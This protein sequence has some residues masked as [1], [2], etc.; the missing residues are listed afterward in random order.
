MDLGLWNVPN[1]NATN[2]QGSASPERSGFS[3]AFFVNYADSYTGVEWSMV[4]ISR[5]RGRS[6][7][8]S[9]GGTT[10]YSEIGRS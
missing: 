10:R 2:R 9:E 7:I 3:W 1:A 8:L 5:I 4:N 6:R